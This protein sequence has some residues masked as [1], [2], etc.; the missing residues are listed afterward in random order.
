MLLLNGTLIVD[1]F[2]MIGGYLTF[3]GL[4]YELEIKKKLKPTQVYLYRWLR[5][6]PVYMLVVFFYGYILEHLG[7]G[8]YWATRVGREAERCRENWWTNFFYINNY[9]NTDKL[10]SGKLNLQ[11]S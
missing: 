11:F 3:I 7:N 2:F 8:P 4:T 6:T 10:V 1:T 5:I 9:V